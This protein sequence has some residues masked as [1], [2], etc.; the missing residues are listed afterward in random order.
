MILL[1]KT[2]VYDVGK[3]QTG[4]CVEVHFFHWPFSNE[5]IKSLGIKT[6]YMPTVLHMIGC[7]KMNRRLH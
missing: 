3:L 2:V 6:E 7:V 4:K 1:K 5:P